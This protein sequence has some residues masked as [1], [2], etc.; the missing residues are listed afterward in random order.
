MQLSL[1]NYNKVFNYDDIRNLIFIKK[2]EIITNEFKHFV[3]NVGINKI[4]SKNKFVKRII[5]IIGDTNL[6]KK[7][8]NFAYEHTQFLK[9]KNKYKLGILS[10]AWRV[11][12]E[13]HEIQNNIY[14]EY[15][16]AHRNIM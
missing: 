15:W 8:S 4:I 12:E 7:W 1:E 9:Y 14:Y 16:S 11:V 6:N 2:K 5:N 3:N 13:I 10:K